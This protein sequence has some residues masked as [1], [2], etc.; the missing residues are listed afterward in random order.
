[1]SIRWRMAIPFLNEESAKMTEYAL[2]LNQEE[3]YVVREN[4]AAR[5]ARSD[6]WWRSGCAVDFS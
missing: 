2:K 4:Y 1:M 6:W 3:D 5:S